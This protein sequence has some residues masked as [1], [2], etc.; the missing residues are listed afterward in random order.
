M[1]LT[2]VIK[3]Y[4]SRLHSF[5]Q[6]AQHVPVT[7]ATG[8]QGRVAGSSAGDAKSAAAVL[9]DLMFLWFRVTESAGL[10]RAL[11]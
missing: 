9:I 1:N 5:K 11:H 2:H 8:D 3:D 6:Q 7:M 10:I 4:F